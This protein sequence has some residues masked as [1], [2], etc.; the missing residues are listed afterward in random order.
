MN[1]YDLRPPPM[2]MYKFHI[3]I[4]LFVVVILIPTRVIFAQKRQPRGRWT[5]AAPQERLERLEEGRWSEL[6]GY[7]AESKNIIFYVFTLIIIFIEVVINRPPTLT[8]HWICRRSNKMSLQKLTR[9][10]ALSLTL[11]SLEELGRNLCCMQRAY[12]WSL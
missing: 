11:V 8:L 1:I 10:L 5:A 7:V 4:S 9:E 3:I 6:D 2:S 12:K